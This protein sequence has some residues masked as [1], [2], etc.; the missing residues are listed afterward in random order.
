M[1]NRVDFVKGQPILDPF[2]VALEQGAGVALVEADEAP[3]G[4]AV[5]GAGQVQRGLVVADGD[6]R[7]DAVPH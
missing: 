1:E 3:V 5:V 6:Q 2:A 4:P 7:G